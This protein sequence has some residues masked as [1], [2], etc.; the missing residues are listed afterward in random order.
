MAVGVAAGVEDDDGVGEAGAGDAAAAGAR[1]VDI[2][3]GAEVGEA[4]GDAV[5]EGVADAAALGGALGSA[6]ADAACFSGACTLSAISRPLTAV[7]A[8]SDT[9]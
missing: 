8:R 6:P 3:V 7:H 4:V 1:G 2:I 5:A 9:R